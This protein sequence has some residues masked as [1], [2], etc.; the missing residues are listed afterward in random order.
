SLPKDADFATFAGT[1]VRI[2]QELFGSASAELSAV[3]GGWEGVGVPFAEAQHPLTRQR[4]RQPSPESKA[5]LRLAPDSDPGP[6]FDGS[7]AGG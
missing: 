1:T 2:A 3:R 5:A 6:A 4:S 7:D